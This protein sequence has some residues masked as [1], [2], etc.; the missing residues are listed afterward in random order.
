M[1]EFKV[2]REVWERLEEERL[3]PWA[4]KSS[5]SKGRERTEEPCPFRTCF[6]RDR[7]R[8][9]H[10]RSFRLLKHK[11]QVLSLPESDHT[12]TRLTH[13][14]EVSQIARTISRALGLNEDLTE[15]IALA[16]DLGHTPFGHAGERVLR[17][18]MRER[19]EDGFHHAEQ[20]LR[21]VDLLERDGRGLNLTWEVRMGIPEHSKGQVDV[22][23][24]FLMEDPS[25]VEAWVVRVSDSIA[26]VNHDLDDALGAK[27]VRIEDVPS[28]VL[29]ILGETHGKRINTLVSDV[30]S[31]SHDGRVIFSDRCI[32]QIEALRSFLYHSVY[33]NDSIG[34]E[35]PKVRF[36][37]RTLF[38]RAVDEQGM[39]PRDA[40]DY[41]SSMT[42]RYALQ[43][44]RRT[45]E[46]K[47]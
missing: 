10:S 6:Q 39:T 22:R 11:T 20:S 42:D 33:M 45:T 38:D 27:I 40:A 25:S 5:Q 14:L 9:I 18:L 7:D 23:R 4:A 46:P 17:A 28:K 43:L 30:V 12:R 1:A 37:I 26:Y 15:A 29:D 32:E 36:V 31:N 2:M 8:I 34:S 44:F 21:V 19:G 35:E 24:G 41:I 16:H 47:A 13:T 3:A